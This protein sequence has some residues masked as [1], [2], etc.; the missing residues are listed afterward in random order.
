[1]RQNFIRISAL[2]AVLVT[3]CS[4]PTGT[5]R[6][7]ATVAKTAD[8]ATT[9]GGQLNIISGNNEI[10]A[11]D[12]FTYQ[13]PAVQVLNSSGS[14]VSG[15]SVVFTTVSVGGVARGAVGFGATAASVTATTQTVTTDASGVAVVRWVYKAR[16]GQQLTATTDGA[17]VTF[18]G[19]ATTGGA[20]PTI[21]MYG[22]QQEWWSA[23]MGGQ[24]TTG[25]NPVV[26]IAD[27]TGPLAGALV[28]WTPN[29]DGNVSESSN[30]TNGA[31]QAAVVW[32]LRTS[33]GAST[34]VASLRYLNASGAPAQQ[35]T[36]SITAKPVGT[37]MVKTPSTQTYATTSAAIGAKFGTRDPAVQILTASGA[38]VGA[39]VAVKVTF[40]ANS[41]F[42]DAA[43]NHY[44]Y[45]LTDANGVVGVPWCNKTAAG[46]TRTVTFTSGTLSLTL[47]GT[48]VQL[49][50]SRTLTVDSPTGNATGV[51][52]KTATP[53]MAVTLTDNAGV[54][55]PSASV[56][57]TANNSGCVAYNSACTTS[58]TVSTNSAGQAA[59]RWNFGPLA[60]AQTVT[61]SSTGATSVTINGTASA[62]VAARIFIVQGDGLTGTKNTFSPRDPTVKVT[63]QYNNTITGT[64]TDGYTCTANTGEC[65]TVTFAVTSGGGSVTNPTVLT[66]LFSGGTAGTSWKLGPN[67]GTNT[68]TATIPNGQF[69]TFTVVGQ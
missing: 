66:G 20:L 56:T 32:R 53:D 7:V 28:N 13:D 33:S 63:D 37:S 44:E 67:A 19:L 43:A 15:A 42:C 6:G 36:F 49:S 38:S 21:T 12:A 55:I 61:V 69:V 10:V 30:R 57:F 25:S 45:E 3:A 54:P 24:N 18:E 35:Q 23:T 34:L 46:G 17:T 51:V 27:A 2:F 26:T 60:G 39:G 11:P 62:D 65:V 16:G 31:G 47:S 22:G 29:S 64:T 1:M 58:V 9:S 52:G 48:I 41:G 59:A 40:D 5:N 4:E 14:P 50:T 68:L 8:V